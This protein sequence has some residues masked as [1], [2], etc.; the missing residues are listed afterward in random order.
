[1]TVFLTVKECDDKLKKLL[2]DELTQFLP[3]DELI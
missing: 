1:M 2:V 3:L